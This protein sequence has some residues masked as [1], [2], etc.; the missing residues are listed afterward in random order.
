MSKTL[1]GSLIAQLAS[2]Y[3]TLKQ[4][5]QDESVNFDLCD[6]KW[7]CPL[8]ILPLSAYIQSTGSTMT[9]D[10]CEING[11]LSNVDFP[12]GIDSVSE[13]Q[14]IIQSRKSYIPISVLRREAGENREK[15]ESMF[16][17]MIFNVLDKALP[18]AKNAI[19]YP[20][21]ELVGNIFEHS[22]QNT[23]Y[24]FGQTYPRK[25]YLDICIVDRGRGL[26]KA[27]QEEKKLI[28]SDEESIKEVMKGNSVKPNKERGYGVRTSRN[29]VCDGLGGQFILI[30]GS[31][32]L[33]SVKNRNQLVN[34]NGFYWPGVIIA[35]RIPKPH[36]PLDI[37]PFLE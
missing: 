2:L 13:F 31:A 1:N 35:Y 16:A 17:A 27:Y 3:N 19:Y 4:L 26:Q 30:S 20:I 7:A 18:N 25:D 15:L 37:T 23:G 36:K 21:G 24:I 8:L 12:D 14:K 33:I 9:A 11:Y 34:L 10:K 32:A 28:I 5:K 6:I 29:V 22:K